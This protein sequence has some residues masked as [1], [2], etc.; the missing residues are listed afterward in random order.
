MTPQHYTVT[1]SNGL[2]ATATLSITITALSGA[3]ANTGGAMTSASSVSA[4]V[5][6]AG[7]ALAG[8]A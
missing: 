1:D 6:W 4:V 8:S 7:T 5:G 2:T 3:A